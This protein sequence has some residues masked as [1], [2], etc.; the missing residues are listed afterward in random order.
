MPGPL[1]A[2]P[3]VVEAAADAVSG[4]P[5]N[6][7]TE[8]PAAA[9]QSV[10]VDDQLPEGLPPREFKPASPV[11]PNPTL[12]AAKDASAAGEPT[13]TPNEQTI[14]LFGPANGARVKSPVTG[15]AESQL[16]PFDISDKPDVK[17]KMPL[18]SGAFEAFLATLLSIVHI[19]NEN[20]WQ[21]EKFARSDGTAEY[22]IRGEQ[23]A[24]FKEVMKLL[25]VSYG[26]QSQYNGTVR[27]VQN[28]PEWEHLTAPTRGNGGS[29]EGDFETIIA[30]AREFQANP[31]SLRRAVHVNTEENSSAFRFERNRAFV[32][33]LQNYRDEHLR[34]ILTSSAF[35]MAQDGDGEIGTMLIRTIS[36]SLYKFMFSE[37]AT[38]IDAM[39]AAADVV[40][41]KYPLPN[42][43]VQEKNPVRALAKGF[44]QLGRVKLDDDAMVAIFEK[45][46]KVDAR[47]FKSMMVGFETCVG[48]IMES[49]K[50]VGMKVV[51]S[52]DFDELKKTDPASHELLTAVF[53]QYPK[54]LSGTVLRNIIYDLIR[55]PQERTSNEHLV[56]IVLRRGAGPILENILQNLAHH[57]MGGLTEM[58]EEM[59]ENN[60][61]APHDVI[62]K[63][64]EADPAGYKLSYLSPKDVG[65]GKLFQVHRVTLEDGRRGVSRTKRPGI[66]RILDDERL[67]LLAMVSDLSRIFFP[68]QED[69]EKRNMQ[70]R[71]MIEAEYQEVLRELDVHATEKN[72]LLAKQ[73]L[74][75]EFTMDS[76]E[77]PIIVKVRVP[78]ILVP[79]HSDSNS[80]IMVE[81]PDVIKT[82]ELTK[83]FPNV[84]RVVGKVLYERFYNSLIFDPLAKGGE[85]QGIG[86]R[87]LHD[88]NALISRPKP[89]PG[90][91]WE[92][93]VNLIDWGLISKLDQATVQSLV[94]LN[95]AALTNQPR[96]ITDALCALT[97]TQQYDRSDVLKIVT[98]YVR[99]LNQLSGEGRY[100]SASEWIVNVSSHAILDFPNSLNGLNRAIISI[101]GAFKRYGN[102]KEEAE[103]I[104]NKL[105]NARR[106]PIWS[107][108][109]KRWPMW[110]TPRFWGGAAAQSVGDTAYSCGQAVAN[111]LDNKPRDTIK[112]GDGIPKIR[113]K[114]SR[115]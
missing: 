63:A 44:R 19:P 74:E 55:E 24:T 78:D 49:L 29:V 101:K 67:M 110:R 48:E 3:A 84:A 2:I 114:R 103:T 41:G 11:N 53:Q 27:K 25:I 112:P 46:Q 56:R 105:R 34:R 31:E 80:M 82:K 94:A 9:V 42:V 113:A 35:A 89:L 4:N 37:L 102:P 1:I 58:F 73:M 40:D 45:L 59:Q 7:S 90:G 93:T 100:W 32:E 86:H 109:Y 22:Y 76:S 98:Q 71:K 111:W 39:E 65:V 77:G 64:L 69:E 57:E 72:Q 26:N 81:A 68:H 51:S 107:L 66:R 12:E 115:D 33:Y 17:V 50:Q 61:A 96:A 70:T 79:T 108:A 83:D 38:T 62:K 23:Y 16:L 75:G 47:Q 6:L 104:L 92:V 5:N 43:S 52:R 97:T 87:D 99:A 106:G 20:N 10:V 60:I 8:K 28:L 91:G 14:L 36:K 13:S 54:L 18:L 88:K 30:M 21:A 85:A 95:F 15:E